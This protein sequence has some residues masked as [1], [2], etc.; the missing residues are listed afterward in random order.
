MPRTLL[1]AR[2]VFSRAVGLLLAEI[3]SK[4]QDFL[5]DQGK[6]TVSEAKWNATHCRVVVN[7]KRCEQPMDKHVAIH[8]FK[9]IGIEQSVHVDG[10]AQDL[11]LVKDGAIVNDPAAYAP[12]GAFWTSLDPAL[13]WGGN[14]KGFPDLGHFSHEWQ[15][16]K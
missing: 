3:N 10:L 4:G 2:V 7:G 9:P 1:Q 11:L 8:D 6:R 15:G 16:R 14:F 12:L 13:A 5:L